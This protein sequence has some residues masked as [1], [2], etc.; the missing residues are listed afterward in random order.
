MPWLAL[1]MWLLLLIFFLLGFWTSRWL[2]GP[3]QIHGGEDLSAELAAARTRHQE[4]EADRAR[5][6]SRAA[7]L[8]GQLEETRKSTDSFAVRLKEAENERARMDKELAAANEA[9]KRVPRL[10]KEAALAAELKARV[11]ELEGKPAKS[12]KK[13]AAKPAPKAA[14]TPPAPVSAAPAAPLP[15]PGSGPTFYDAPIAGAPDDLKRIK[16][17]GPKLEKTLNE[18]GVFY[19]RQIAAWTPDQVIEV[20]EKLQQ[21]PG[22]I[23]RD[24]WVGQARALLGG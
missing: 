21:F 16:G 10:E 5:L 19:Y 11:S 17:V 12:A 8:S 1:Q 15:A 13:P 3:R 23:E 14:E 4:C 6:K 7:E 20:D 18:L 9:A 2:G 22:R 24:D